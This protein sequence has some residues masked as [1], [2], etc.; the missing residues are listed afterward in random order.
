[1][2]FSDCGMQVQADDTWDSTTNARK[3]IK[4]ESIFEDEF[5]I[6]V[7]EF[8]VVCLKVVC[9]FYVSMAIFSLYVLVHVFI[10]GDYQTGTMSRV[11][12]M[13]SNQCHLCKT[14]F[15]TKSRP[16]KKEFHPECNIT[17]DQCTILF[18]N[19]R[20]FLSIQFPHNPLDR[21]PD[22]ADF[23]RASCGPICWN[24]SRH[25]LV[26]SSSVLLMRKRSFCRLGLLILII[27]IT[28]HT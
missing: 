13:N 5:G 19:Y 21:Q 14:W 25:V 2:A 10:S 8:G 17:D 20:I 4:F 28:H 11:L 12:K 23:Y 6:R 1:M 22:N 27:T 16:N 18:T 26:Q 15:H 3:T 9:C 24:V 7:S